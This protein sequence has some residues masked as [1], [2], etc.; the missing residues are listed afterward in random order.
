MGVCLSLA[1]IPNRITHDEWREIYEESLSI[2][3]QLK[4]K[5]AGMG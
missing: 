4:R 5:Q 3:C 1:I 2:L